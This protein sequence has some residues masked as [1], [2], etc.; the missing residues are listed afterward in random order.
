[1]TALLPLTTVIEGGG[2]FAQSVKFCA[3]CQGLPTGPVR[4][5]MRELKKEQRRALREVIETA[6]AN[7]ES[8][9]NEGL[10][11]EEKNH[12]KLVK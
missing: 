6:R 12:V 11:S 5:P 1:M 8:I 10:T 4:P 2:K 3:E 9:L 7:L